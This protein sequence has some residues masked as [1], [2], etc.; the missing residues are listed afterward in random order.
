[1]ASRIGPQGGGNVSAPSIPVGLPTDAR[2]DMV[3]EVMAAQLVTQLAE[4]EGLL[5]QVVDTG[6]AVIQGRIDTRT[7][8]TIER[9]TQPGVVV[10]ERSSGAGP[11]PSNVQVQAALQ[12]LQRAA[13]LPVT[14]RFDAQTN[15]LLGQLGLLSP[16]SSPTSPASPASPTSPTSPSNVVVAGND[17]PEVQAPTTRAPVDPRQQVAQRQKTGQQDRQLRVAVEKF[18]PQGSASSTQPSPLPSTSKPLDRALDPARLLASLVAAGFS[19]NGP[20][21]VSGFQRQQ[22]LPPTG[23]LDP[24]TVDALVKEGHLPPEA[25]TAKAT[26]PSKKASNDAPD[27]KSSAK[28][29]ATQGER[30]GP[31]TRAD[32]RDLSARSGQNASSTSSKATAVK[33][34]ANSPAEA[35]EQARVESLQA[36]QVATQRGVQENTGDPTAVAGTGLPVAQAGS[37]VSGAG[38]SGGGADSDGDE[39]SRIVTEG[40][41]GEETS[42]GNSDAGDDNHD[43][44]DRGEA[45]AAVGDDDFVD[46]DSVIPDGYHRVPSLAAQVAASLD[47]IVRTDEISVPVLYCWD[48]TLYRPGIYADLQPAEAIW[49]LAVENAHAFDRVWAQAADALAS[50]LLYLEPDADPVTLDD[51]Q[52]ALRRARVRGAVET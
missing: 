19:G 50:R 34:S 27:S 37:G 46:D 42:L 11:P 8:Q 20:Q 26:T 35:R 41:P 7:R 48:A 6:E 1:M 30:G 29:A 39:A 9:L 18:A 43:D 4:V 23:Q 12:A 36:Q 5:K 32:T 31:K 49:R 15:V 25:A 3:R 44:E 16:T 47:Q 52:G 24:H 21:A 38:A 2:R 14:G 10:G 40:P 17:G 28:D 22:G 51:I 33:V 13:G 45:V